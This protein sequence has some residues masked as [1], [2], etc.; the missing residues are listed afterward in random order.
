MLLTVKMVPSPHRSGSWLIS[1]EPSIFILVP[2]SSPFCLVRSSTCA[3]AAILAKASPRNPMVRRAKRSVAECIFDVAW[4]SNERRA[5]VSLMPLPLSITCKE[6][7][8]ASVTMSSIDVAPASRL[9]SSSS[10]TMEAG[11]WMTSPAAIWLA[12]LSGKRWMISDI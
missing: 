10:L 12:T 11:R 7:F 4:R 9:F 1:R 3:T 6:V 2:I 8:P 5:S